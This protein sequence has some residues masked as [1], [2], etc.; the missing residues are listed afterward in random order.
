MTGRRGARRAALA[1][2]AG[3]LAAT[4]LAVAAA[5]GCELTETELIEPAD[6][7][8]AESQVV[9]TLERGGRGDP[10]EPP[11]V[12]MAA[13][14]LL[15]KLFGARP[16]GLDGATVRIAGESGAPVVFVEV[17]G[18]EC[19]ARRDEREFLPEA[20]C[21]VAPAATAPFAPGEALE[22]EVRASGGQ[23]L[24]GNSRV[25]GTFSFLDAAPADA[26][27]ADSACRLEPDTNYRLRWTPADGVWTYVAEA[28]FFGLRAPLAARGIDADDTLDLLGVSI[29]REDSE[30]VFPRDLGVFDLFEGTDEEVEVLRA[31]QDGLPAG[32]RASV[33]ISAV[34]RNWSNWARGGDFHPSGDVRI[35]SVYGDG[36]GVFGTAVQ[37]RL[38]V[39][40]SGTGASGSELP[41]CGLP[42][43]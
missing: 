3:S 14:T 42:G 29:G 20:S 8:I 35:S 21:Y 18:E 1:C 39:V 36:G 38:E 12:R 15:H 13:T 9:V 33:S 11:V 41:A 40:A 27:S 6:A 22:L 34:D 32:V 25:P 43:A 28:Q 37:R 19:V 24:T 30:I 7:I 16:G 2:R 31:L 26:A 23:V 10:A 4:G 17:P 5:T